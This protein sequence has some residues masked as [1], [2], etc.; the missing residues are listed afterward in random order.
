MDALYFFG[1]QIIPYNVEALRWSLTQ[2]L[3]CSSKPP[4]HASLEVGGFRLVN[5][6]PTQRA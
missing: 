2:R 5:L 4:L 6:R 1:H 3:V